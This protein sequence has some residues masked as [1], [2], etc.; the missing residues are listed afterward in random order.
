MCIRAFAV[1]L[2]VFLLNSLKGLF[3]IS[4]GITFTPEYY[5]K[6]TLPLPPPPPPQGS[7]L[8]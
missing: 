8:P 2:V 7:V 3:S 1:F 6:Y 5:I 4:A